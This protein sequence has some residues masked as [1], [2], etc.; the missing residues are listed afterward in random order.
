MSLELLRDPE[1]LL[2]GKRQIERNSCLLLGF[3][4]YLFSCLQGNG[5]MKPRW[6]LNLEEFKRRFDPAT[7]NGEGNKQVWR[8]GTGR[9][10]ACA[11]IHATFVNVRTDYAFLLSKGNLSISFPCCPDRSNL[12]EKPLLCLHCCP[13]SYHQGSAILGT[14]AI[15]HRRLWRRCKSPTT[16]ASSFDKVEVWPS[17]LSLSNSLFKLLN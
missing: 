2:A 3:L 7:T 1:G 13:Q 12:A 17:F 8:D 9:D 4:F 11:R 15:L 14:T 16:C 6:G 5:L 10:L